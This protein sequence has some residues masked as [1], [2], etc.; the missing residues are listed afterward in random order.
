MKYIKLDLSFGDKI[1]LLFLGVV[2]EYSLP[3][4]IV[5]IVQVSENIDIDAQPVRPESIN[6]TEEEESFIV[7][8]FDF[9]DD[10]TKSNF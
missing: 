10:E 8:F 4:E 5:E 2:P 9:D 1:R 3:I 6:N 7:P